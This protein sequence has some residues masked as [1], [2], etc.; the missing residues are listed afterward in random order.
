VA[1]ATPIP[2]TVFVGRNQGFVTDST[3]VVVGE[4]L[5]GDSYPVFN[6]KVIGS[7]YDSN[8]NLV[9]AEESLT[10][11]HQIEPELSSP[12][13]IQV[14]NNGGNIDH[15]ELTL[16][17]DDVS[18]IDYEEL[19]IERAEADEDAGKIVGELRNEGSVSVQDIAVVV[20]LYNDENNV[21]N[22]L[23]GM[24]DKAVLGTNEVASYEIS[25]PPDVE[26][27]RFEVQAQG[28]LKLF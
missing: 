7:F 14:T 4:V 17:W 19:T 18:I 6:V 15:Y 12:F 28:A 16:T 3:Y 5:N 10:V 24:V 27:T 2:R 22:V 25:V 26:F 23:S 8:N 13:K 20:T 21:V 9:A 11:F 1:T